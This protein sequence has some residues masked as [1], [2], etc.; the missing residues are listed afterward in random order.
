MNSL[1]ELL[2]YLREKHPGVY[3]TLPDIGGSTQQPQPL[4]PMPDFNLPWATPKRPPPNFNLPWTRP[5]RPMPDFNLPY[6][7]GI[8][9][10]PD[11][12]YWKNPFRKKPRW[13]GGRDWKNPDPGFGVSPPG[14]GKNLDPGF[15]FSPP[16]L[17]EYDP[18]SKWYNPNWRQEAE[19][20]RGLPPG[21]LV[22]LI[23]PSQAENSP[24]WGRPRW[25]KRRDRFGRGD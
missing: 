20:R 13:P 2:D 1:Q 21:H 17:P 8:P 15:Q 23:P 24:F 11:E 6:R 22:H 7:P 19:E 18:E 12:R 16:S 3:Q 25:Q 14:G 9:Q 10:W 4:R 5:N